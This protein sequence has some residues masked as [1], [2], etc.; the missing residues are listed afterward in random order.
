MN[1]EKET[2]GCQAA[3]QGESSKKTEQAV[4]A[5]ALIADS[6]S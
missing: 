3:G 4:I 5:K 1:P 2:P 6:M